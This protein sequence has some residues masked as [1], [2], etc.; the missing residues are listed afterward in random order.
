MPLDPKNN[1]QYTIYRDQQGRV[2]VPKVSSV[3]GITKVHEYAVGDVIKSTD[4][5]NNYYVV[6]RAERSGSDFYTLDI[7]ELKRTAPFVS[8]R[9]PRVGDIEYTDSSNSLA[10]DRVYRAHRDDISKRIRINAI[11]I[12]PSDPEDSTSPN[13]RQYELVVSGK[14]DRGPSIITTIHTDTD[15][16][17]NVRRYP[18]RV[19]LRNVLNRPGQY[20]KSDLVYGPAAGNI[21][22]NITANVSAQLTHKGVHAHH[23]SLTDTVLSDAELQSKRRFNS[24]RGGGGLKDPAYRV[25]KINAQIDVLRRRNYNLS[26]GGI[27]DPVEFVSSKLW[28]YDK[29]DKELGLESLNSLIRQNGRLQIPESLRL[30]LSNVLPGYNGAP[31]S[32]ATLSKKLRDLDINL[33]RSIREGIVS[34]FTVKELSQ[35]SNLGRLRLLAGESIGSTL[36][37]NRSN[38]R[39]KI[40]ELLIQIQN[41]ID[42][43][44]ISRELENLVS[45]NDYSTLFETLRRIQRQSKNVSGTYR[46]SA[47]KFTRSILE[48]ILGKDVAIARRNFD[49]LLNLQREAILDLSTFKMATDPESLYEQSEDYLIGSRLHYNRPSKRYLD[50]NTSETLV[51]RGPQ[52]PGSFVVKKNLDY[53]GPQPGLREGLS[54]P[55]LG[56]LNIDFD[57]ARRVAEGNQAARLA[58]LIKKKADISRTIGN[59]SRFYEGSLKQRIVLERFTRK[60]NAPYVEVDVAPN[61]LGEV[62]QLR[63]I[64]SIYNRQSRV[65]GRKPDPVN[66]ISQQGSLARLVSFNPDTRSFT[67]QLLT[68][69]SLPIIE[70]DQPVP[71]VLP[72]QANV[73]GI[74]KELN[75]DRPTEP[76]RSTALLQGLKVLTS[77]DPTDDE[78]LTAST[79]VS[80]TLVNRLIANSPL[81]RADFVPSTAQR[82]ILRSLGLGDSSATDAILR[83]FSTK[84]KR[85]AADEDTLADFGIYITEQISSIVNNSS[86]VERAAASIGTFINNFDYAKVLAAS[87]RRTQSVS[88]PSTIIDTADSIAVVDQYYGL[89]QDL[90]G[91][92]KGFRALSGVEN[93]SSDTYET[94]VRETGEKGIANIAIM[95]LHK[96]GATSATSRDLLKDLYNLGRGDLS[97]RRRQ[98]IRTKIVQRIGIPYTLL[99]QALAETSQES[100]LLDFDELITKFTNR[101]TSVDLSEEKQRKLINVYIAHINESRLNLLNSKD[102]LPDGLDESKIDELTRKVANLP[103]P[104]SKRLTYL[105]S[106]NSYGFAVGDGRFI[107]GTNQLLLQGPGAKKVLDIGLDRFIELPEDVVARSFTHSQISTLIED[108]RTNPFAKIRSNPNT[109]NIKETSILDYIRANSDDSRL[110]LPDNVEALSPQTRTLFESANRVLFLDI[111]TY[112]DPAGNPVIGNVAFREFNVTSGKSQKL[113]SIVTSEYARIEKVSPTDIADEVVTN[114]R[115]LL[116]RFGEAAGLIGPT[117][118]R[119]LPIAG[120]NVAGDV[121]ELLAGFARHNINL[122]ESSVEQFGSKII[123][124]L[125]VSRQLL[126]GL[127]S[128]TLE[129]VGKEITDYFSN[130]AVQAHIADP[131]LDLNERVYTA[132]KGLMQAP[133]STWNASSTVLGTIKD[134]KAGSYLYADNRIYQV[135]GLIA[136]SQLSAITKEIQEDNRFAL[137]LRRAEGSLT[138]SDVQDIFDIRYGA[139]TTAIADTLANFDV[140]DE[141]KAKSI[142]ENLVTDRG[143]RRVRRLLTGNKSFETLL[144]ERQR[145]DII[146]ASNSSLD[147][148]VVSRSLEGIARSSDATFVEQTLARRTANWLNSFGTD[149]LIRAQIVRQSGIWNSEMKVH[150][151]VIDTLFEEVNRSVDKFTY[152]DAIKEASRTWNRYLADIEQSFF[153]SNPDASWERVASNNNLTPRSIVLTNPSLAENYGFR[154]RLNSDDT[155]S[156]SLDR[157]LARYLEVN[158]TAVAESIK[159]DSALSS[160]LE[161]SLRSSGL[162]A[163]NLFAGARGRN[164]RERVYQSFVSAF[165]SDDSS[166]ELR[167]GNRSAVGI[168]VELPSTYAD[169]VSTLRAKYGTVDI[170]TPDFANYLGRP[171]NYSSDA[172]RETIEVA[173]ENVMRGYGRGKKLVFGPQHVGARNWYGYTPDQLFQNVVEGGSDELATELMRIARETAGSDADIIMDSVKRNNEPIWRQYIGEAQSQYSTQT[174]DISATQRMIRDINVSG[175][176]V[177]ESFEG[178]HRN[179]LNILDNPKSALMTGAAAIILLGGALALGTRHRIEHTQRQKPEAEPEGFA[180][181][182]EQIQ[183]RKAERESMITIPQYHSLSVNIS[184]RDDTGISDQELLSSIQSTLGSMFTKEPKV[185]RPAV[186]RQDKFLNSR[187]IQDMYKQQIALRR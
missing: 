81:A 132:L 32:Y 186:N 135:A 145:Y 175:R 97:R 31:I 153:A 20:L 105:P 64:Q 79:F 77:A 10:V 144:L 126:P 84:L 88:V 57:Y 162:K 17:G 156:S 161:G 5:A 149:P 93:F 18:A 155:V 37:L 29:L 89:D 136:P 139:T 86:T 44:I 61:L 3:D 56:K 4:G 111:E 187:D 170:N 53:V 122:P 125:D 119:D 68:T 92:Q 99:D 114:E 121:Q 133:D 174:Q 43:E 59:A 168:K 141:A 73:I 33:S 67:A 140:V 109:A 169:A 130:R 75:I 52:N 22:N 45:A 9:N 106:E 1:P 21:G 146:S 158:K 171:R 117:G 182:P 113:A 138:G 185:I 36:G 50:V 7:V 62:V 148:T 100:L 183:N 39:Q 120:H 150:Q 116:Y 154:I 91:I 72:K 102:L 40:V 151:R 177:R 165:Q 27:A 181:S 172:A 8:F 104:I 129:A 184:L 54:N 83:K 85:A 49:R 78:F 163:N 69:Q 13:R 118:P 70:F 80:Q 26:A 164:L 15:L 19:N 95:H 131:D 34:R 58:G 23:I 87:N 28:L 180:S 11:I 82:R 110:V 157:A 127:K 25:T 30:Y 173:T 143:S 2:H 128:H 134:Y 65:K 6:L 90:S 115:A 38:R 159:E 178:K 107:L 41:P 124:T 60:I 103:E 71:Y 137:V 101:I 98:S 94:L 142:I 176:T 112:K 179:I 152:E 35:P 160:Y 51:P 12:A 16:N 66:P 76:V 167:A 166:L 96:N 24:L 147:P 14:G 63:D 123:D 42:R 47:T 46:S 74:L 48:L 108:K 55:G